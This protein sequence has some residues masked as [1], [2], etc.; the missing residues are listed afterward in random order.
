MTYPIRVALIG[1]AIGVLLPC[2]V[3]ALQ[4]VSPQRLSHLMQVRWGEE[5]LLG[6]WP[7]SLLLLGAQEGDGIFIPAVSVLIN[8]VLYALIFF[9]LGLLWKRFA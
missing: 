7:S 1:F 5:V 3:L 6:V 9:F 2:A 4:Y 8:G